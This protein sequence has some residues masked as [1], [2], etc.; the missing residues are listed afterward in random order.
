MVRLGINARKKCWKAEAVQC[1][2]EKKKAKRARR[3]GNVEEAKDGPKQKGLG[4]QTKGKRLWLQ[5][6]MDP[7]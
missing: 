6:M 3:G 7:R 5:E 4:I 2:A 1:T